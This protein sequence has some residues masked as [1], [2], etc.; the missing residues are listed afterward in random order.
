MIQQNLTYY[1]SSSTAVLLDNN[2][3]EQIF[4]NSSCS[5]SGEAIQT[6]VSHS[7]EAAHDHDVTTRIRIYVGGNI[8]ASFP[9]HQ[10]NF[11]IDSS[12]MNYV[13]SS[14]N[15]QIQY[16]VFSQIQTSSSYYFK[17]INSSSL[18][19]ELNITIPPQYTKL[20]GILSV[21]GSKHIFQ[22]YSGN[23][24]F[25]TIKLYDSSSNLI[26][27]VS[28]VGT[29]S[30]S[31]ILETTGSNYYIISASVQ[32]ILYPPKLYAIDNSNQP[33]YLI[34]N[35]S[36]GSGVSASYVFLEKSGNQILWSSLNVITGSYPILSGSYPGKTTFYRIKTY[37][38]GNLGEI[39]NGTIGEY[40]SD[41]SNVL[42][43]TL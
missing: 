26:N 40:Y 20:K 17:V 1:V 30:Y 38:S 7:D 28:W 37:F 3:V 36:T 16:D 29:S 2:K 11:Y 9:Y 42:G 34:F 35:Y 24:K 15:I 5:I 41:Y 21:S 39:Y 25:N 13:T 32:D 19:N 8:V 43:Y 27:S 6:N 18:V 12:S 14:N 23:D 33:S 10:T 31:S 4:Y 22:L